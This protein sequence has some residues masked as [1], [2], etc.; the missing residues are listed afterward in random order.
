WLLDREVRQVETCPGAVTGGAAHAL[1]VPAG[2]AETGRELVD[3]RRDLSD[4]VPQFGRTVHQLSGA[5]GQLARPLVE[6]GAAVGQRR[7]ALTQLRHAFVQAGELRARR[8][9]PALRLETVQRR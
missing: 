2:L 6:P 4:A 5:L 3:Q 1:Q 7:Q 8:G 9:R